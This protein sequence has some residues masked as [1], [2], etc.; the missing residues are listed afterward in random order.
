MICRYL[1]GSIDYFTKN[2]CFSGYFGFK[3]ILNMI[4]SVNLMINLYRQTDTRFKNKSL[5]PANKSHTASMNLKISNDQP[6]ENTQR[7][8]LKHS[9]R[10]HEDDSKSRSAHKYKKSLILQDTTIHLIKK[11]SDYYG[12]KNKEQGMSTERF[13]KEKLHKRS[14]D[15]GVNRMKTEID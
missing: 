2:Q 11:N 12:V 8:P 13:S 9:Y 6:L 10:Q 1:W 14:V 3:P 4:I 15:Y 5:Y 7:D